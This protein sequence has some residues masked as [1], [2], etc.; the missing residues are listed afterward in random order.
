M[1]RLSCR[2]LVRK[3]CVAYLTNDHHKLFQNM[4]IIN[5]QLVSIARCV[6]EGNIISFNAD[7]SCILE[8]LRVLSHPA[9]LD[10]Y[11]SLPE[12]SALKDA[13]PGLL[14]QY[15]RLNSQSVYKVGSSHSPVAPQALSDDTNCSTSPSSH[16][17]RLDIT[18]ACLTISPASPIERLSILQRFGRPI[19]SFRP[20]LSVLTPGRQRHVNDALSMAHSVCCLPPDVLWMLTQEASF[21]S[22]GDITGESFHTSICGAPLCSLSAFMSVGLAKRAAPPSDLACSEDPEL[23]FKVDEAVSTLLRHHVLSRQ[24]EECSLER[25]QASART[26]VSAKLPPARF[27]ILGLRETRQLLTEPLFKN[28]VFALLKGENVVIR[29]KQDDRVLIMSVVRALSIFIP[30]NVLYCGT[31]SDCPTPPLYVE[32]RDGTLDIC[33]LGGAK[34]VGGP[35]SLEIHDRAK[36]FV[37]KV[38]IG[39]KNITAVIPRHQPP[40]RP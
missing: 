33:D 38:S 26:S 31:Q 20:L 13:L 12:Y 10:R 11:S 21:M 5:Q 3:V 9:A 16:L 2:G 22:Q 36:S 27:E 8:Q 1:K 6:C 29:G 39:D 28:I 40:P 37:S 15:E 17:N 14:Q 7:V 18:S 19:D 34:L 35:M 24:A 23:R 32:W 4:Q 25:M 30:Q